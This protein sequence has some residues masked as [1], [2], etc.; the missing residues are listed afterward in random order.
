M[1]NPSRR[2]PIR[3]SRRL[4]ST[5]GLRVRRASIRGGQPNQRARRPIMRDPPSNV[6]GG[7]RAKSRL[8]V[9]DALPPIIRRLWAI[10]GRSSI[11]VLLSLEPTPDGSDTSPAWL[12]NAQRWGEDLRKR[13]GGPVTL[14]LMDVLISVDV[15][16]DDGTVIADLC[17]RDP[18]A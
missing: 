10:E 5:R 8:T 2:D 1:I 11:L 7:F 6:C 14:Q 3:A 15:S 4:G 13:L 16:L 17:W 9:W 18:C 12:A